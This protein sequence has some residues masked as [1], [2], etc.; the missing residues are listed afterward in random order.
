MDLDMTKLD[1]D[2]MPKNEA[3]AVL[4]ES[5]GI[6]GELAK[7]YADS[8]D[9][10]SMETDSEDSDESVSARSEGEVLVTGPIVSNSMGAMFAEFFGEGAVTSPGQFA[11]DVKVATKE[12][13]DG[14]TV[15]INSPG[16]MT[17]QASVIYNKMVEVRKET[18]IQ[19]IVDGISASAATLLHFATDDVLVGPMADIMIHNAHYG[20]LNAA[21]MRALATQ[22][23]ITSKSARDIYAKRMDPEAI[24]AD[25]IESL[26]SGDDGADGT[27]FTPQ[28]AVSVGLATG[29]LEES[30]TNEKE[31]NIE[32]SAE[33][34]KALA[35]IAVNSYKR[36]KKLMQLGLDIDI[37]DHLTDDSEQVVKE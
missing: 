34:Y 6:D 22:L 12:S 28:D 5:I 7:K 32:L 4:M 18:P 37:T 11:K 26:M 29:L 14:I 36:K 24:G 17:Q 25:S 2:S 16:G 3:F 33:D 35:D 9:Y 23:D 20:G 19:V 27:Y 10:P 15:R 30:D 8:C 13:P 21:K 31:S 1:L